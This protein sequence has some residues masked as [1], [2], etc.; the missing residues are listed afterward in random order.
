M[1]ATY[2][3]IAQSVTDLWQVR[4][5]W[6]GDDGLPGTNTIY[7]STGDTDVDDLRTALDSFY[8]DY[9]AGQCSDDLTATIPA[10]GDKI[11]S[12]TGQVSGLWS[13]GTPLVNTGAD[14]GNR[15]TDISQIL[16]QLRTDLVVNG[17]LLRGR[18][19]LP[20]FRVTGT[21]NGGVNPTQV[22]DIK[23]IAEDAFVG[24]CCVYSRTHHTFATIDS[25]T[26]W[27]QMAS[28]R[29]RRG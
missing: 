23:N 5:L 21:Q 4:V 10:A 29:S 18:I 2:G 19:F 3:R 28:L 1:I 17:R 27:D 12:E 6:T 7:A 13:S 24:R 16:V 8:N 11:D 15:V 14:T 9:C 25:V 20:G 26:V 22:T